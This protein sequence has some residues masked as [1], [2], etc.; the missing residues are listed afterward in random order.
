MHGKARISDEQHRHFA[1]SE[2]SLV[3]ASRDWSCERSCREVGS[4][5]RE[6]P[7]FGFLTLRVAPAHMKG[8]FEDC[9][10]QCA[11]NRFRKTTAKLEGVTMSAQSHLPLKKTA[12]TKVQKFPQAW[13]P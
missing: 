11:A 5:Q 3:A 8:G 13:R 7:A 1:V 6:A 2:K 4:G 10:R 12:D 9:G